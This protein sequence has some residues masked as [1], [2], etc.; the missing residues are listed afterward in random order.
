MLRL[1]I[2]LCVLATA[3]GCASVRQ[4]E[5]GSGPLEAGALP[6][7][8]P[9][10]GILVVHVHTDIPIAKLQISQMTALTDLPKGEH[11]R[12]LAL[13]EGRY[14]WSGIVIPAGE[15]D[16]P[17]RAGRGE[18]WEFRV[19]PGRINYPGELTFRG[20]TR[21]KSVDLGRIVFRNR[22]AQMLRTLRERFPALLERYP[23][24]YTGQ[25]SDEYLEYYG[26]TFLAPGGGDEAVS[27]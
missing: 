23:P 12:L 26:K 2:A 15:G 8:A 6:D 25:K 7:L 18:F 13:G 11:L 17:F 3:S 16:V 19:E 4:L 20:K 1:R 9:D 14:R 27:H 24:V 21:K 10:E 5:I 22:S